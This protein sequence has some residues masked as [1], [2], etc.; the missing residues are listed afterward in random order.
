MSVMDLDLVKAADIADEKLKK[1]LISVMQG[2]KMT[3]TILLK[4]LANN[5]IVK[6]PS[7]VGQKFDP[8]FHEA[9]MR[10]PDPSKP[11]GTVFHVIAEGYMINDR[12]LRPT[13]V[14]VA[15]SEA[16]DDLPSFDEQDVEQQAD[17]Q[18]NEQKKE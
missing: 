2:V 8:K 6:I 17:Q 7:P 18:A 11:S 5:G 15:V 13:Q 3:H 1:K 16:D 12:V 4:T 9:M 10:K 14:A